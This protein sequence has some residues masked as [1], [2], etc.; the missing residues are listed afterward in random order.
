MAIETAPAIKEKLLTAEEL[1]EMGDIGP[2]ELVEGKIV[3]MTPPGEEHGTIEA[4]ITFALKLYLKSNPIG[5][6]V[7]GEGG[8]ITR[9]DPDT[10]R[11]VDV[12]FIAADRPARDTTKFLPFAPDLA[13]EIISPSDR[14]S[15]IEAKI[16]EYL[17]AG[18]RLA[19]V[20]D[21]RSKT[22][23]VYRPDADIRRLTTA[24]TLNGEDVLPGFSMAVSEV[25]AE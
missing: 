19:W 7:T 24:D 6:V 5:K 3:A 22:V 16:E 17:S 18:T 8:V 23:R 12:M 10:V 4:N 1:F 20:V 21:P 15:E 14:W 2:C 11:G 13:V 25:F 9:R